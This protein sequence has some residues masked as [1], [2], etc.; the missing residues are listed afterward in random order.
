MYWLGLVA[1]R[2]EHI[3]LAHAYLGRRWVRVA[4][5]RDCG[6]FG[7]RG[8]DDTLEAIACRKRARARA[9]RHYFWSMSRAF[10]E[11]GEVMEPGGILV[12]AT[13]DSV[14]CSVPVETTR[15]LGELASDRFAMRNHF[16]YVLRNRYMQYPLRNGIGIR[17]EHILV[18]ERRS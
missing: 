8:L 11:I 17:R 1:D 13:G 10:A 6:E 12:C 2:E 18:L 14:S 15:Y 16:S 5:W 9:L 7:V 4:D 3:G